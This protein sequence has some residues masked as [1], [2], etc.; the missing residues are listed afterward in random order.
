MKQEDFFKM[1][2]GA[3]EQDITEMMQYH[4]SRGSSA[5]KEHTMKQHSGNA[6][7]ILFSDAD[8]QHGR[9]EIRM[10]R[11]KNFAATAVAAALLALNIGGGYL[12][13]HN[14]VPAAPAGTS[15]P[16]D[17]ESGIEI[18]T[19]ETTAA[20]IAEESETITEP[21]PD[22]SEYG[23]LMR[24]L[25]TAQNGKECTFNFAG[26]GIDCND[27]W[28]ND[29]YRMTLR[30]ICGCDWMLFYF[31]D[32][33]PKQ[34]QTFN[35]YADARPLISLNADCGGRTI[36]SQCA[37]EMPDQGEE[38]SDGVWHCYGLLSNVGDV[39][40]FDEA[41]SSTLKIVASTPESKTEITQLPMNFISRHDPLRDAAPPHCIEFFCDQVNQITDRDD[42]LALYQSWTRNE[43]DH[44]LTRCAFTPFGAYH[45][46]EG[47]PSDERYEEI[48]R[49]GQAFLDVIDPYDSKGPYVYF[50]AAGESHDLPLSD[51]FT[52]MGQNMTGQGT[53]YA[54]IM[55]AEPIDTE[56]YEIGYTPAPGYGTDDT[57]PDTIMDDPGEE[58]LPEEQVPQWNSAPADSIPEEAVSPAD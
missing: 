16:Q 7:P 27:T 38:L 54:Q 42:P 35:D 44:P 41:G 43:K 19:V 47:V 53:L 29:A 51:V 9:G 39:P 57:T 2:D 40:F 1:M 5:R 23:S 45:V 20:P 12:L 28:E 14:R 13:L 34:G 6:D 37:G 30:G 4:R 46:S 21:E 11:N 25:Y 8:L 32:V 31:Y 22:H 26:L 58:V 50:D 36:Y 48:C 52:I 55:F 3:S 17:E 15:L 18:Q 56:Q 10:S 24:E 49:P 33:E